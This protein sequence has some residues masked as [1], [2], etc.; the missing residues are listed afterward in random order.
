M[1]IRDSSDAVLGGRGA[2]VPVAICVV[3]A[4]LASIITT[5]STEA[6][7]D[8]SRVAAPRDLTGA[9][10]EG[11]MVGRGVLLGAAIG[12][13]M[14][15]LAAG[16]MAAGTSFE[17]QLLLGEQILI[18]TIAWAVPIALVIRWMAVRS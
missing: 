3:A 16:M 6:D 9:G 5:P 10:W 18:G 11:R 17:H 1:A 12:I 4:I 2:F 14:G 7:L 15:A 13:S 8:T